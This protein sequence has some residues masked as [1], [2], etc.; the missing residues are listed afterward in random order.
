MPVV[1]DRDGVEYI[2][3]SDEH[4]VIEDPNGA[5]KIPD[6]LRLVPGRCDPTANILDGYGGVGNGKVEASWP[7]SARGKEH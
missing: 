5:S 2:K 6:T 4:G 3:C 7:V 1:R